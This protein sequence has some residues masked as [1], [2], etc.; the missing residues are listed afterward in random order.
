MS[1]WGTKNDTRDQNVAKTSPQKKTNHVKHDF[2]KRGH[3]LFMYNHVSSYLCLTGF[4][5][6]VTQSQQFFWKLSTKFW[7]HQCLLRDLNQH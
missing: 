4:L 2:M 5:H 7:V 6:V 1:D 3:Q